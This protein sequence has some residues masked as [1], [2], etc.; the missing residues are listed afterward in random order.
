L[1]APTPVPIGV[2]GSANMDLVVTAD[3]APGRGETVLGRGFTTGPGGKGA[4]QAVAAARAGAAVRMVGAVGRDEFGDRVLAAL[5]AS[6]VDTAGVRRTAAPTGTAHIVVD[7]AGENSI[8]VVP[9]ANGSLDRLTAGDE[10]LLAGCRLVLLQLELPLPAVVAAAAAA[11]AAG[12]RVVLTPA[13]IPAGPLPDRLWSDVD[14]VVPNEHE[15]G[16]LTGTAD[17]AAAATAL[18][19]LVPAAVVTL[20]D[21]GCRYAD[22][23]GRRLAVPAR[24]VAAVD[25]TAAGDTFAGALAVA[26]AEGAGVAAALEWATAAAALAVQRPGASASMPTRAEIDALAGP[27]RPA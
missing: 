1:T 23:S 9:G 26:L 13:P 11:R 15:A 4:N 10:R 21:R 18:L 2:V 8:V 12:A 14:I 19:D 17:P 25:T 22:R 5:R 20:G 6:G 16:R 27:A 7:A 3:R 24:P